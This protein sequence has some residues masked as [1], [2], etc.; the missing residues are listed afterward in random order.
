M[1][2]FQDDK[3]KAVRVFPQPP[4]LPWELCFPHPA[5]IYIIE[6]RPTE[7]I[8]YRTSFDTKEAASFHVVL[9]T[10]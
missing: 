9:I 1:H 4:W 2:V 7:N 5:R 8:L 3:A 6:L 10:N